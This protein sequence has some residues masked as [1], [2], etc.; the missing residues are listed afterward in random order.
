MALYYSSAVREPWC[1]LG[2]SR[3]LVRSLKEKGV[4]ISEVDTAEMDAGKLKEMYIS[5]AVLPSVRK[6]YKISNLF[7]TRRIS[8]YFFG[9]QQPGL[10]VLREDTSTPVDV[11]P[12][13]EDGQRVTIADFLRKELARKLDTARPAI[14]LEQEN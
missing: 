2:D 6:K 7:G 12:H 14:E 11:Y 10:I 1:D 13:V 3:G 8:G 4:K 9:R 5:L